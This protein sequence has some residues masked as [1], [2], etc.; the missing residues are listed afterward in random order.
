MRQFLLKNLLP[1]SPLAF[2]V[3]IDILSDALPSLGEF[4]LECTDSECPRF[5]DPALFIRGTRS[6]YIQPEYLPVMERM[7]PKM[8]MVEFEGSHWIHADQP[9]GVFRTM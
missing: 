7:F 8:E 6:R 9:E 5:D 4:P 2:Q 3:P 1:T